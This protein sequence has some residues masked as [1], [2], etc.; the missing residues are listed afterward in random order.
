MLLTAPVIPVSLIVPD[1]PVLCA[2]IA[3]LGNCSLIGL[4]PVDVSLFIFLQF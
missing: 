4:I 2:T 3:P 1:E